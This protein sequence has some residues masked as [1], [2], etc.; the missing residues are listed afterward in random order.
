MLEEAYD[1]VILSLFQL[2]IGV[3]MRKTVQIYN[4]L[5]K[6][7]PNMELGKSV[8]EKIEL[9]LQLLRRWNATINLTSI[10]S[11][12]EQF[13]KHILDSLAVYKDSKACEIPAGKIL[14]M[15]SGAGLPGIVLNI[16]KP[17][18]EVVSV[19]KSE[20]KITFQQHVKAQLRLT[21]LFPIAGRLESLAEDAAHI[22]RYD[23]VVSRAFRQLTALFRYGSV[24]LKREGKLLLWK[25]R[26]WREEYQSVPNDLKK[27][28]H[29]LREKRYDFEQY[30]VGGSILVF[31]K[32]TSSLSN[33]KE[34]PA[35]S[36]KN[37]PPM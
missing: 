9:F 27:Q 37:V 12:K 20:R 25:G 31:S 24:F 5:E 10:Q 30:N 14:D 32:S 35:N 34:P 13:A 29:T 17:E 33:V 6:E 3:D 36:Q 1:F 8:P 7:F 11:Q 21:R 22:G 23:I 2:L 19:D 16:V 26:R 15:G 4:V 18:L 28:F